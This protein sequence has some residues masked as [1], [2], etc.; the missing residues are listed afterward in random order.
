MAKVVSRISQTRSS[1]KNSL[2]GSKTM[3]ARRKRM[4]KNRRLRNLRQ[5]KFYIKRI[6]LKTFHGKN[7]Q[8]CPLKFFITPLA[9]ILKSSYF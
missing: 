6:S 2:K 4:K 5:Q 8:M 9:K 7:M 3:K 1:T